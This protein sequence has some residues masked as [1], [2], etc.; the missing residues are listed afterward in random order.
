MT[1]ET[2]PL[3]RAAAGR[4]LAAA[5][6]AT[7]L[8][9]GAAAGEAVRIEL[10][11]RVQVADA[12]VRLGDVARISGAPLPR[13][14]QLGGVR[15]GRMPDSGDSLVL[16]R[17]AVARWVRSQTGLAPGQVSWTGSP[18]VELSW[19]RHALQGARIEQFA[20]EGLLKWLA[21]H[22][23]RAQ[24]E[25]L[26]EV[27]DQQIPAGPRQVQLKLRPIAE[28]LPRARMQAWVDIYA[29]E[30]FLRAVPVRFKVE[31]WKSL[32]VAAQDIPGGSPLQAGS[33]IPVREVDLAALPPGEAAQA[34]AAGPSLAFDQ[35]MRFKRA[36]QAGDALTPSHFEP[37]PAVARG[38]WA[39]LRSGSG[40]VVLESRVQVAQD[41]RVGQSIRVKPAQSAS[42]VWA[43]VTGPQSLELVQ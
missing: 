2:V 9:H 42:F 16:D 41:A 38:D 35:P 23:E 30:R 12:E 5:A 34:A 18:T 20:R 21:G 33:E 4:A 27:A 8:W 17:E 3:G 10:Q 24:V 19:P 14:A 40:A 31:A 13:Q 15:L 22:S 36:V 32:P 28:A 43:R 37:L 29:G 6:C 1:W 25:S 11:S 39:V 26:G 7:G